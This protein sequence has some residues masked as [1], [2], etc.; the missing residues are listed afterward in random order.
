[1]DNKILTLLLAIDKMSPGGESVVL[2][3]KELIDTLF[4]G[5][6]M[7][8]DELKQLV[9]ELTIGGYIRLFYED[10]KVVCLAALPKGL[11]IAE[12]TKSDS[13]LAAVKKTTE[14]KPIRK[15][16]LALVVFWAAFAGSA[17]GGAALYLVLK[18]L[19]MG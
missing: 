9:K 3:K 19:G 13:N 7:K 10:D 17:A 5:S 6:G 1:M 8:E 14:P 4:P 16:R 2:E 12:E 11:L 15:G 18:L